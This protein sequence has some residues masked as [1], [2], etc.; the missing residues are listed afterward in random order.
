MMID[1]KAIEARINWLNASLND[2]LAWG[3]DDNTHP[4][5]LK[6]CTDTID[7]LQRELAQLTRDLKHANEINE[8]ATA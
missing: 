7:A 6:H 4:S 2:S 1:T 3:L 8:R 5:L